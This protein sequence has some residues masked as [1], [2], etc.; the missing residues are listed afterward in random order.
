LRDN[1]AAFAEKASRQANVEL[2]QHGG[3]LM[4]GDKVR[5]IGRHTLDNADLESELFSLQ[6]GEVSKLIETHQGI[7]IAKCDRRITPD[8]T[9]L[10]ESVRKQ[11][12]KKIKERKMELESQLI[13][14]EL[15]KRA[16][17]RL[18]LKDLDQS[19][20]LTTEVHRDLKG[21]EKLLKSGD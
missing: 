13:N 16:E 19:V 21:A 12:S 8:K 14:A 10:L 20:D 1:E 18:L 2:A 3:H 6:P 11:L 15:H 4:D 5:Q 7:V 17:P 9:V